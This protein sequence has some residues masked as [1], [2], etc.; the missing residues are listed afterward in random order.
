L[1]KFEVFIYILKRRFV[2]DDWGMVQVI[3][4]LPRMVE[5]LSSI[6]SIAKNKKIFKRCIQKP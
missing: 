3:E 6:P 1:K 2:K 4:H 5:T